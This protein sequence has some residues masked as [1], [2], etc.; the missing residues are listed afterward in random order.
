M[1]MDINE[2]QFINSTRF[3]IALK[4]LGS[5]SYPDFL[6]EKEQEVFDKFVRNIDEL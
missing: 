3:D 5:N 6:T 1:D 2:Y 4:Y